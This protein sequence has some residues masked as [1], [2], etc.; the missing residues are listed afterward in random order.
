M[1]REKYVTTG[2]RNCSLEELVAKFNE[3]HPGLNIQIPNQQSKCIID[4]LRGT[5][6]N[7]DGVIIRRDR[8]RIIS[9]KKTISMPE[10]IEIECNSRDKMKRVRDCLLE[11]LDALGLKESDVVTKKTKEELAM[12]L[13]GKEQG[14]HR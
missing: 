9:D 12:E 10:I 14:E 13:I 1:E 4:T 8:S 2:A 5:M 11:F 7:E 3:E 6:E